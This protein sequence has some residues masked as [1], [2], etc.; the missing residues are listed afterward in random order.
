MPA[1][2][3]SPAVQVCGLLQAFERDVILDDLDNA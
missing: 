2:T 3:V 1:W